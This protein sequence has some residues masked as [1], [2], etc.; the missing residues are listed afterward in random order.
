MTPFRNNILA[1]FPSE[2][3]VLW[4][5][6]LMALLCGAILLLIVVF[7]GWKALP[8]FNQIGVVNFFTDVAWEPTSGQ[9]N[10]LPMLLGTILTS[11]GAIMV[12]TPAGIISA[13][14]IHYYA[15]GAIAP[16]YRRLI[17]LLAGIPSV[18]YGFWGLVVLVPLINHI[19]SPGA[20][21]LAG[22]CILSIMIL[23]TV[24]LVTDSSFTNVSER[25][26]SS[27]K[28]LGLGRW[29]TVWGIVLP[30]SKSGMVAGVVLATGRALGE[31]MAVVM[32][33]GN[34]VQVPNSLFAPVRTLTANIALE[35]GYAMGEH[36][37]ALFFSGLVLMVLVALLIGL[38]R[39]Q[40]ESS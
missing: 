7:L 26:L 25:Y 38:G 21:L 30:A 28:A 6:R 2:A 11:L 15:P 16:L 24:A 12:A 9:Y 5:L 37:A 3:L 29:A 35:M 19:Q 39:T 17:E 4:L 23:P 32:V 22:I 18:V 40:V 27:A 8:V 31:T 13:I 33:C 1:Q 10:L 20:S 34:V 14:F 36:R